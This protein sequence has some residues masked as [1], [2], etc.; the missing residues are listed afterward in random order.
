MI[1]FTA[2]LGGLVFLLSSPAWADGEALKGTLQNQGQPVNG[3]KISVAGEDGNPVGDATTGA[4]GKWEVPVPK[5]GKYK[6]TLDQSTLPKDVGLKFQ[7]RATLDVQVYEGS[8]RN[9]L[10]ALAPAGKQ[11]EGAAQTSDSSSFWDRV[12]QLTF[13]GFNLGLIIALA[14]MGLSLVFGTTGLTNFAHGELLT[15]GAM[16]AYFFNVVIGLPLIVAAVISVVIGGAFGYSQDRFFWG[17]LR[18]RGSSLVAMMIISIGLA[19]FLRYVFLFFFGGEGASFADY[20][21]QPGIQVGP[22]SAA[23]K[24]FIAMGIELAV[25]I[26][27][28]LA[29]LKTRVGKAA[30]AVADNPALAASSGI[31][32]DGVIRIIWTVGGAVASLAGVMLG[33]SQNVSYQM[34]FQILL[35]VFAGVTLGGLGTAFGA[36]V[37]SIVVG[38]FIQLSTVVVP[39]ELK[40]VGALLVLILVMLFRPQGILG[41]RERIG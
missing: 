7:N 31:N 29:L 24:N 26:V 17:V 11:G 6:V 36:L 8:E 16:C 28:G 32:V 41:R 15:F 10:F 14:A 2:F 22:I 21:A 37:G 18:R 12:A 34:G 23:P 25:L 5:A 9:V 19:L 39:T 38:L 4:D 27:V 3:V 40:T 20:N 30:R 13:E 35:L 1:A 33:L